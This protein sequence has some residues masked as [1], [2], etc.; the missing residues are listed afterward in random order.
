MATHTSE[1][2]RFADALRRILKAKPEDVKDDSARKHPP[3]AKRAKHS[4]RDSNPH[5]QDSPSP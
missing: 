5:P 2:S 3:K 1:R 4:G